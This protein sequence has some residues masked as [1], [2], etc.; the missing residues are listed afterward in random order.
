M[1]ATTEESVKQQEA[2]ETRRPS[3]TE[4]IPDTQDEHT[5][6]DEEDQRPASRDGSDKDTVCPLR[7]MSPAAHTVQKALASAAAPPTAAHTRC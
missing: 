5:D 4:S 7:C 1:S 3:E 2:H 6:S